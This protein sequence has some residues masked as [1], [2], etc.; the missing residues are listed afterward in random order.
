MEVA[1]TPIRDSVFISWGC[2]EKWLQTNG[3]L[4][5]TALSLFPWGSR[6]QKY[7]SKV[8]AEWIPSAGSERGSARCLPPSSS[9]APG[10]P[11]CPSFLKAS[12]P[13][14]LH[15]PSSWDLPATHLCCPTLFKKT[16]ICLG[17]W[18]L[19]VAHEIHHHCVMQELLRWVAAS[20]TV[21]VE[22]SWSLNAGS[23]FPDQ[24]LNPH[25]LPL[26]GG[27]LTAEPPRKSLPF[28]L[29]GL[30]SLYLRLTLSQVRSL[31]NESSVNY[32]CKDPLV[33]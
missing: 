28:F 8:W 19:V 14:C 2:H 9:G 30:L 26:Q 33:K 10:G 1:R 18:A 13:G 12:L 7:K 23:Y 6:G 5:T 16:F 11:R 3:R 29:V 22:L 15:L 21:A 20:L 27:F 24:R 31:F 32:I 4:K 17:H 25:P